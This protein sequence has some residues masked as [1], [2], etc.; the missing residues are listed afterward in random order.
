[1]LAVVQVAHLEMQVVQVVQVVAEVVKVQLALSLL[2][3]VQ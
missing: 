2:F 3:P 1:V